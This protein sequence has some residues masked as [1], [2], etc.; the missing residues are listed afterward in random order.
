MGL[1]LKTYEI[2]KENEA[3]A[4]GLAEIIDSLEQS[5][6][7]NESATK[8]DVR[9]TELRLIKEIEQNRFQMKEIELSL[10]KE[11]ETVRSSTIKWIIGLWFTQT[12]AIAA[13]IYTVI[14]QIK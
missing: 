5:I 4:K 3:I 1:A 10:L 8:Q 9:E 7:Q 11:I 12:I 2:F 13:F 6:K 14:V